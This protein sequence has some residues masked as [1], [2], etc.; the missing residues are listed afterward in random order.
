MNQGV[1][2][3]RE[4][5]NKRQEEREGARAANR[6]LRFDWMNG[7]GAEERKR[8]RAPFVCLQL[9]NTRNNINTNTN[10]HTRTSKGQKSVFPLP[11]SLSLFLFLSLNVW[12]SVRSFQSRR[13]PVH[14]FSTAVA[15]VSNVVILPLSL[16]LHP[17]LLFP[18][19]SSLMVPEIGPFLFDQKTL[20]VF[21]SLPSLLWSPPCSS[22]Y[23]SDFS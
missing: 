8:V 21:V 23:T 2:S 4:P 18:R 6:T 12:M 17:L 1:C 3:L 13:C 16:F 14:F 11:F 10:M 5:M 19:P 7:A 20:I 15:V 9:S 22:N